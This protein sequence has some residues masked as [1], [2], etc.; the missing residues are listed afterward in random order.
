MIG[1]DIKNGQFVVYP[2]GEV[3][4]SLE[5]KITKSYYRKVGEKYQLKV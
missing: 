5:G 1:I 4:T 3:L 2:S